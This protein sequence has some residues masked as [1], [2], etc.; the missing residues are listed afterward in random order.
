[1]AADFTNSQNHSM[2]LRFDFS[3][4]IRRRKHSTRM[5]IARLPAVSRGIPGPVSRGWVPTHPGHTPRHKYPYPKPPGKDVVPEIPTPRK[6]WDQRYPPSPVDRHP[7]FQCP[8]VNYTLKV[9]GCRLSSLI[10]IRVPNRTIVA[11]IYR[12]KT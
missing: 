4:I 5:R 6:I 8:V 3:D 12:F 7:F 11:V 9:M 2:F 1:M 10:K